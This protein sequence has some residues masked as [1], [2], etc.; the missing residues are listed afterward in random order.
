MIFMTNLKTDFM[1]D[2]QK[3]YEISNGLNDNLNSFYKCFEENEFGDKKKAK[4]IDDFLE[5]I[6][7][8]KNDKNRL[9]VIR[10]LVTLK[11]DFLISEIESEDLDEESKKEILS[12]GYTWAGSYHISMF[13]ELIYE[14]E[15]KDLLNP[16][17][18]ELIKGVKS[19]GISFTQLDVSWDSAINEI[20]S[21][22]LNKFNNKVEDTINF[23][24]KN[25]LMDK[26]PDGTTGDRSYSILVEDE[27]SS[28]GFST[29]SYGEFFEVEVDE[30]CSKLHDLI[31]VLDELS[32]DIFDM[33]DNWV[34]YFESIIHAL[35]ER[36]CDN[37]ISLWREVDFAW[38]DVDCP[39]QVGHCMEYYN[40]NI[41]NC[42][43]IEWDLR[44]VNPKRND[45]SS[46][47][48]ATKSM[49]NQFLSGKENCENY[50]DINEV[51]Q[52]GLDNVQ[53]YVGKPLLYFAKFFHGFFSAQV[54]PNDEFV[55]SKR[56]KKIFAFADFILELEKTAPSMKL[57]HKV[58]GK[59]FLDELKKVACETPDIWHKTYSISTIGHEFGHILWKGSDSEIKMNGSGNFKNIEEYKATTGGLVSFFKS[60]EVE[61]YWKEVF[62]DVVERAVK[63]IAWKKTKSVWPYY[64][65]GL[66][67]LTGLFETGVLNFDN[68]SEQLSM[69][70][71]NPMDTNL[72]TDSPMEN[73]D[74]FKG[75][76]KIDMSKDSFDKFAGWTIKNYE[77]LF[78]V[79][80]DKS[81]A[82]LFL[83]NFAKKDSEGFF[84]PVDLKVLEF[85]S[86]YY[87]LY[88]QIGR[89][90]L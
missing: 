35:S 21:I 77:Q 27:N 60:D 78:N 56:G 73:G 64:C 67:H 84:M 23:I 39:I 86:W 19:I 37:L 87:K 7:F 30:I 89:E 8:E 17:Y 29:Q 14:M 34:K 79:Y 1:E 22:L 28:C 50:S 26:L 83:D 33:K 43:E 3:V 2:L 88:E 72:N 71:A 13:E 4:F 38:M 82:S 46:V 41:R 74:N 24:H 54:V 51:S 76:L 49:Y 47:V 66:V 58:F 36:D 45:A 12:A 18:R 61:T 70:N 6:N 11:D 62:Y 44:V 85:V 90:T 20:N 15:E 53:L 65:E 57:S 55:S 52:K 63:L 80:L 48:S 81:D 16:F 25:D 5:S 32:D 75:N 31:L 9:S 42:V 68:E 59:E 69:V 40:D 10:R